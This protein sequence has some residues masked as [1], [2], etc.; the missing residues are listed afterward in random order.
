[1]QLLPGLHQEGMWRGKQGLCQV[2]TDYLFF[3]F[4]VA[5]KANSYFK[6]LRICLSTFSYG[7]EYVQN[8][9]RKG[10][11]LHSDFPLPRHIS[12]FVKQITY[13]QFTSRFNSPSTQQCHFQ[14]PLPS[15]VFS[16]GNLYAY[17][18]ICRY[19]RT[20]QLYSSYQQCN[21]RAK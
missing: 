15:N 8:Y 18:T 3:G 10:F 12:I 17:I 14:H 7:Q 5:G 21:L 11:S 4:F 13:S 1:M 20:A 16:A 2:L 19:L 6:W 9:L